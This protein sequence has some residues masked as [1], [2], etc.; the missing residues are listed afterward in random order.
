MNDADLLVN[1]GLLPLNL[2][3]EPPPQRTAVVIGVARGGTTMAASV[4]QALGVYMG[5]RL[6]PVLEDLTLSKAVESKDTRAVDAI[7]AERNERFDVWGWKRPAAFR[8][9]PVWQPRLRNPYLIVVYR[10]PFAIANRNRISML[11]ECLHGIKDATRQLE[12]LNGFVQEARVP[13]LLCSYEKAMTRPEDFV[14]GVTAF[15]GLEGEGRH[16]AAVAAIGANRRYL[17]SSRI[18]AARGYVDIV[19]RQYC[20]GWAFYIRQ[21]NRQVGRQ[22]RAAT[23]IVMVNGTEAGR[24][25]AD[26]PRPDVR[27]AGF[28]ET[29]NCGFCFYWPAT[30]VPGEGDLVTVRVE[31][32]LY[33]L[34]G[35]GTAGPD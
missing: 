35:A 7:V 33:P 14:S 3:E 27:A 21:P 26:S 11:Q 24:I 5:D 18:T 32:D 22:R 28:H 13:T 20:A 4:L 17:R 31:G 25:P 10:D 30:A 12:Q 29:G 15:L 16:K 1:R 9:A 19:N 8:Y 23:V 34:P 6:G 2:P